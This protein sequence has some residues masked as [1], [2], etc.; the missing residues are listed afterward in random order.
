MAGWDVS[1]S[2]EGPSGS[3][4][5]Q[6]SCKQNADP[7]YCRFRTTDPAPGTWTLTVS[8]SSPD[9]QHFTVLAS[10]E[11]PRPDC[12]VDLLPRVQRE[13]APTLITAGVYFETN[14]DG[15]VTLDGTVRRPDGSTV[16][17]AIPHEATY[18][19]HAVPFGAY[20]GRG[21][22]EVRLRCD[23]GAK[24]LP[25]K[26]EPIF[27][28]PERPDIQVTPFVRTA[29]TSLFLDVEQLPPCSSFD[30]DGDGLPNS[31]DR[32]DQDTDDDGRPDCRDGDADGD[33]IPDSQEARTDVDGDG[34]PAFLDTDAD[35]DGIP[36]VYDPEPAVRAACD[37]GARGA[38]RGTAGNDVLTGTQGDDVLCGLGGDDVISGRGG[39]DCI[40]AGGGDD[41]VSAGRGDD[42]VLAGKG[43]DVVRG[44]GGDDLLLG[45][46]G[47]DLLL[48]GA[49][50][51]LVLGGGGRDRLN[52]GAAPD[53]LLGGAGDDAL[54]GGGDD[55]LLL[56]GA[57]IDQLAGGPGFDVCATGEA[58]SGCEE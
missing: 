49:G 18:A 40:D 50:E 48:G 4:F 2:L 34:V 29:T 56:G 16:P 42:V 27:A 22:Y 37:C 51:D 33:E 1:F 47:D 19:G 31:V 13:L 53:R 24:T 45:S 14:L 21:V 32:C 25:A 52:G 9:P 43:D 10:V 46:S 26:G 8:S 5:E 38:I 57:G 11:N 41:R 17:F 36:D 44:N 23:V 54:R 35:G 30:C 3:V 15:D 58:Q 55:D 6:A 12:F 20:V 7:Y 39:N 28:G